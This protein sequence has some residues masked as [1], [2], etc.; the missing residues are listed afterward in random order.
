MFLMM[1][2]RLTPDVRVIHTRLVIGQGDERGVR[3]P[4]V[5]QV[6]QDFLV[7]DRQA[8]HVL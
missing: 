6:Q 7:V 2:C 3:G 4:P 5:H 8:V 1:V